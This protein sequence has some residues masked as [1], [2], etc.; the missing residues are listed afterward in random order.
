MADANV[1]N[2]TYDYVIQNNGTLDEFKNN[3]KIFYENIIKEGCL[4]ESNA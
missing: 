3:V 1:Y 2:Y 4:N